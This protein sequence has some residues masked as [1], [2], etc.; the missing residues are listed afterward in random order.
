MFLSLRAL[1][2]QDPENDLVAVFLTQ[3]MGQNPARPLHP[4]FTTLVYSALAT[5]VP[6]L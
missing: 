5:P 2:V 6:R 3:M 1:C 4:P